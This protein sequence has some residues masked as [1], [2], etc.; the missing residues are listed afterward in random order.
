MF[1]SNFEQK[2]HSIAQK[3]STNQKNHKKRKTKRQKK[4]FYIEHYC[5]K[6]RPKTTNRHHKWHLYN[7]KI[8]KSKK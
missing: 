5:T 7:K 3:T 1:S 6:D 8:N 2:T 4:L